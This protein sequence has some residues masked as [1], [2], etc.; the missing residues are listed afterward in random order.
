MGT[1][2]VHPTSDLFHLRVGC[3][4]FDVERLSF[5]GR[6]STLDG[7]VHNR[8]SGAVKVNKKRRP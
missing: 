1:K 2:N 3:S 7:K 5:L 4:M 8:D 6:P